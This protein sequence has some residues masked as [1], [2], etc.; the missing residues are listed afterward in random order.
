MF[1]KINSIIIHLKIKKTFKKELSI[2]ITSKLNSNE[3]KLITDPQR[4]SYI[5]LD[6]ENTFIEQ[7]KW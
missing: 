7:Q 3:V 1:I 6:A 2:T 4:H 5:N